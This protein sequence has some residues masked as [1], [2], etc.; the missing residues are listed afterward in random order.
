[1]FI[2][3]L[4]TS[5]SH[6]SVPSEFLTNNLPIAPE[7]KKIEKYVNVNGVSALRRGQIAGFSIPVGQGTGFMQKNSGYVTGVVEVKIDPMKK[8]TDYGKQTEYGY[9]NHFRGVVNAGFPMTA[10]NVFDPALAFT[11]RPQFKFHN[12]SHMKKTQKLTING[13]SAYH[14]TSQN[15]ML[16]ACASLVKSEFTDDMDR[17]LNTSD[18]SPV[19]LET[20]KALELRSDALTPIT[21]VDYS[22]MRWNFV[23]KLDCPILDHESQDFP[24][25][26]LNGTMNYE[27]M[28]EDD[29]QYVFDVRCMQVSDFIL[30]DLQFHYTALL[31]GP[32]YESQTVNEAYNLPFSSF[33]SG[34]QSS[35][36]GRMDFRATQ[37]CESMTGFMCVPYSRMNV[38]DVKPIFAVA[39]ARPGEQGFAYSTQLGVTIDAIDSIFRGYSKGLGVYGG[40]ESFPSTYQMTIDASPFFAREW[41]PKNEPGIVAEYIQKF[42]DSHLYNYRNTSHTSQSDHPREIDG[43]LG[44]DNVDIN[45]PYGTARN[46][47][48]STV[49]SNVSHSNVLAFDT[50]SITDN[51]RLMSGIPTLANITTTMTNTPRVVGSNLIK[52]NYRAVGLPISSNATAIDEITDSNICGNLLAV[53]KPEPSTQLTFFGSADVQS[54]K[55]TMSLDHYVYY[56]VIHERNLVMGGGNISLSRV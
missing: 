40:R 10:T 47:N 22:T 50:R 42:I 35:Q 6:M 43:I 15:V 8:T 37:S 24:L 34:Y 48:N 3:S 36:S 12:A 7:V 41:S 23:M 18:F 56:F 51:G 30:T 53:Q 19:F 39:T 28:V 32:E 14:Q 44:P 13:L 26:K 25:Y 21:Q 45:V 20:S 11:E 27:F 33:F 52:T 4:Y 1:M 29:V 31:P 49:T 16:E 2:Y 38:V 46:N 9:G 17:G 5:V 54:A 55:L